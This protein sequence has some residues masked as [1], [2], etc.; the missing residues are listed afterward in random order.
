MRGPEGVEGAVVEVVRAGVD[1][2]QVRGAGTA[3]G[4]AT[5]TAPGGGER[6]R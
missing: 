3:P 6:A 4:E 2:C 1:A 5:G